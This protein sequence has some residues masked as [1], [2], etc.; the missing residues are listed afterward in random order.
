MHVWMDFR[1]TIDWEIVNVI[2]TWATIRL[3]SA[4]NIVSLPPPTS[5]FEI[6]TRGRSQS[7]KRKCIRYIDTPHTGNSRTQQNYVQGAT[8][9]ITQI[10]RFRLG[11]LIHLHIMFLGN[12][13]MYNLFRNL[14]LQKPQY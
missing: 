10:K 5:F 1:L 6:R 9:P 14:K 2:S 8:K 12:R 3:I 13:N 7:G 4:A 11:I